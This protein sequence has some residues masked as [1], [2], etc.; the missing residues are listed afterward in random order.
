MSFLRRQESMFPLLSVMSIFFY[1]SSLLSMPCQS[2]GTPSSKHLAER[3]R[4]CF[5]LRSSGSAVRISVRSATLN[6]N[7]SWARRNSSPAFLIDTTISLKDVVNWP[8]SSLLYVTLSEV[9]GSSFKFDIVESGFTC[10]NR[11]DRP[12]RS[13]MCC[14]WC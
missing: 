2:S 6:S 4:Y 8:I 10:W 3:L 11:A 12:M 14:N 5:V 1:H 9:E 13:A 7:S